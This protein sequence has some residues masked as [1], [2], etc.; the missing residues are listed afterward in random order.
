MRSLV[1]KAG[2]GI[3]LAGFAVFL[4]SFFLVDFQLTEAG[5]EQQLGDKGRESLLKSVAAPILE[6]RFGSSFSFSQELEKTIHQANAQILK[7]FGISETEKEKIVLSQGTPFPVE[8]SIEKAISALEEGEQAVFKSSQ[9]RA[10]GGWMDGRSYNSKEQLL[11]DLNQNILNI[12]QGIVRDKGFDEYRTKSL[13]YSLAKEATVG[14]VKDHPVLFLLFTY[15]LAIVGALLYFYARSQTTEGISNDRIHFSSMMH[16]GWIGVLT[17]T[18][19]IGFYIILYFFPQ[20]MTAWVTMVDPISFFLKGSEA[21][22]F[23]LYGWLYTL[24]VLVMGIRMMVKWR[25]S[26]YHLVRTLSVMFFQT[27]FA[28]LIPE[29]LV[30]LNQPYFD[31]KNIWPL[32]YDFFFEYE[33]DKLIESG[34]LGMFMLV[35]GIAL[36][37]IAVPVLVYFF[38]KRWYCSWVCGCGGLAETLGD[39]YRQLSDKSLKAWKVERWLI[40]SVLVFAVIMT[41]GVLYTYFTSSSQFL[42]ISTY[43]IRSW[44]GFLIGS[45]F[46]GVVGTGFYPLMGNRVWCRFGC[47]LAAYLGLVQRFKSRFRITTNGGQCIS[48]GNCSTYC[49]MGIDVRWYA[50]RG[51]NIVRA[52]CVGCGICASVC[53]RGVLKLEN[54]DEETRFNEPILIGNKDVTIK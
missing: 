30:R 9:L 46:A 40:H 16:R 43:D 35:W 8:F 51:Q 17:G 47:P 41:I 4:A 45:V 27:A 7:D 38:G 49:E 48:C 19:L 13:K 29:I 3:F 39:P 26:N 1:E 18:F 14:T 52:S 31:F 25:H 24:C 2:L 32:D 15:G 34:A 23:F 42:G 37:V 11:N 33:L 54:S 21:G 53:P 12:N 22:Y 10:Y 20:H 36:I 6:K 50:Q 5:I 44:Y 28:F